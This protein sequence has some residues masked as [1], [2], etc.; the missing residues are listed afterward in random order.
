MYVNDAWLLYEQLEQNKNCEVNI[1][2]LNSLVYLFSCAIKTHELEAK[3]LPQ[4]ERHRIAHDV[5]TYQHLT[6]LYLNLNE[7]DKV[8]ELYYKSIEAGH[9]PTW[10]LM[11]NFL[12]ASIKKTDPN[13][14]TEA[15]QKFSELE[16]SPKPQLLSKLSQVPNMPD[17]LYMILKTKF[18][19]FGPLK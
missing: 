7:L 18:M 4:F 8:V 11:T 17:K 2:I 16:M 9:T 15:L 14:I 19:P 5:N 13:L 3:V 12:V 6:K 10:R 1:Y